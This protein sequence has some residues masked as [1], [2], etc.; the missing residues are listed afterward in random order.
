MGV[1]IPFRVCFAMTVNKA[2]GLSLGVVGVDLQTSCFSH[3]QVH[4]ALSRITDVDRLAILFDTEE[5]ESTDHVVY[6]EILLRPV[7]PWLSLYIV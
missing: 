1:S 7:I 3:G 6:S 2:Q 5:E 4:V